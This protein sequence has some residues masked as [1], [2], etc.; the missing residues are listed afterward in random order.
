MG[1]YG[2]GQIAVDLQ[3][4]NLLKP[5]NVNNYYA[6]YLNKSLLK[7]IKHTDRYKKQ[8]LNILLISPNSKSL[9]L[10]DLYKRFKLL[11]TYPKEQ[12]I[13]GKYINEII[14]IDTYIQ[15]IVDAVPVLVNNLDEGI[16]ERKTMIKASYVNIFESTKFQSLIDDYYYT[17]K[18]IFVPSYNTGIIPFQSIQYFNPNLT[19]NLNDTD[20]ISLFFKDYIYTYLF[21]QYQYT[22]KTFNEP[23]TLNGKDYYI[24]LDENY[25]FTI[26][27]EKTKDIVKTT[28]NN[29]NTVNTEVIT[30]INKYFIVLKSTE[31]T[32][33]S[34]DDNIQYKDFPITIEVPASIVLPYNIKVNNEEFTFN[35]RI[36]G[37]NIEYL[38]EYINEDNEVIKTKS[39]PFSFIVDFNMLDDIDQSAI[40]SPDLIYPINDNDKENINLPLI[41][42]NLKK[43]LTNFSIK[44]EE[45]LSNSDLRT[46]PNINLLNIARAEL[47]V[48]ITLGGDIDRQN[49]FISHYC[50]PVEYYQPSYDEGS[51][52]PNFRGTNW[53]YSK[54]LGDTSNSNGEDFIQKRKKDEQILLHSLNKL[55]FN[56]DTFAFNAY[57]QNMSY[58]DDKGIKRTIQKFPFRNIFGREKDIKISNEFG[59]YGGYNRPSLFYGI[60]FNV[61]VYKGNANKTTIINKPN[62]EGKIEGNTSSPMSLGEIA[63]V[64]YFFETI[65]SKIYDNTL[66][67]L[68]SIEN[69]TFNN[70]YGT[71]KNNVNKSI[72]INSC[73]YYKYTKDNEEFSDIKTKIKN[74]KFYIE[75]LTR[76]TAKVYKLTNTQTIE[77]I[78]FNIQYNGLVKLN[79]DKI[80]I[81]KGAVTKKPKTNDAY[82]YV[83][84]VSMLADNMQEGVQLPINI[85]AYLKVPPILR[86]E[87]YINSTKL[88]LYS[89]GM[90]GTV[91]SE[92]WVQ[93]LTLFASAV[94]LILSVF[95]TVFPPT[96]PASVAG[97]TATITGIVGATGGLITNILVTTGAIDAK[98]AMVLNLVF[99]VIGLAGAGTS[100]GIGLANSALNALD[101]TIKI[102]Q[103]LDQVTQ[104]AIQAYNIYNYD[105]LEKLEKERQNFLTNAQNT[106]NS[107]NSILE[108]YNQENNLNIQDLMEIFYG[109]PSNVTPTQFFKVSKT[110]GFDY[111]QLYK[112]PEDVSNYVSN[113]LRLK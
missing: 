106:L 98:T 50:Y 33:N 4:I 87:V 104:I 21:Q 81:E 43:A 28:D 112:A 3:A 19:L 113:C 69:I 73:T 78:Y 77:C 46:I 34:T 110:L 95:L 86:I 93:V 17:S 85:E 102:C 25:T 53:Q 60:E 8:L 18:N 94:T 107:Y 111:S 51:L 23:I 79:F 75:I 80:H 52:D 65:L 5:N 108:Q 41:I 30:G 45:I 84:N 70:Q 74:K 64:Y 35:N 68:D 31:E 27:V 91:K 29:G 42:F 13:Q 62:K 71:N 109:S 88:A 14:N 39:I 6:Y 2:Q 56:L 72:K 82:S 47:E 48:D 20:D 66:T 54:L 44:K 40:I 55:G 92:T 99:G 97:W 37:I 63:Y 76:N 100:F 10:V 24:N 11:Q 61:A 59:A 96:V 32:D 9:E 57:R 15:N 58:Y 26:Q 12:T 16:T 7:R 67:H 103:L 22:D 89:I 38:F 1:Q 105:R 36:I 83:G 49:T 101:I 90:G